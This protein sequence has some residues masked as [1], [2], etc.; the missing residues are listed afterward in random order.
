MHPTGAWDNRL[1]LYTADWSYE[2]EACVAGKSVTNR[3]S[4]SLPSPKAHDDNGDDSWPLL[5]SSPE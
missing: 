1:C 3:L 2:G 4:L 5:T